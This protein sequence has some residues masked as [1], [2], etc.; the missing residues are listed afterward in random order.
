MQARFKPT[1]YTQFKQIN[2][3]VKQRLWPLSRCEFVLA[4]RSLPKVI[5]FHV[6]DFQSSTQLFHKFIINSIEWTSFII[7]IEILVFFFLIMKELWIFEVIREHL[8]VIAAN[9]SRW[10]F[11]VWT[12]VGKCNICMKKFDLDKSHV[13]RLRIEI[14]CVNKSKI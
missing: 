11:R 6:R 8:I 12:K 9:E 13:S 10:K 14:L 7:R 3:N 4:P 5:W 2:K 1:Y